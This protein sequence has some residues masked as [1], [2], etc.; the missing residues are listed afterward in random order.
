MY[1]YH[2]QSPCLSSSACHVFYLASWRCPVTFPSLSTTYFTPLAPETCNW[3][4]PTDNA[5][6]T[7][8]S[9]IVQLV[10]RRPTT[11]NNAAPTVVSAPQWLAIRRLIRASQLVLLT[12]YTFTRKWPYCEYFLILLRCYSHTPPISQF[13]HLRLAGTLSPRWALLPH[14]PSLARAAPGTS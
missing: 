1:I 5:G 4:S 12:R 6:L 8:A 3:P 13:H 11:I 14:Q 2:L 9:A 7:V 10:V